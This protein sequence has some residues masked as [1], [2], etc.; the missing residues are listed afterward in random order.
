[1]HDILN[2]FFPGIFDVII[3]GDD[4]HESKPSPVPYLNAVEKL[5]VPKEHCLVVENAPMGIRS[6][7]SAGLRCLAIPTYLDRKFLEEAD[8]IV[9]SHRELG[10]YIR[11]EE[12]REAREEHG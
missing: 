12:E 3:D 2:A 8:I 10:E 6:A 9:E 1:V 11:Q 7:K 5:G 4:T